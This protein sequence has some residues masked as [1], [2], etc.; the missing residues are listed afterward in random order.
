ELVER[1]FILEEDQQAVTLRAR[2][3]TEADLGHLGRAHLLALPE[4]A[5][6]AVS[7]AD[8]EPGLA[9]GREHGVAVAL[10]EEG[11]A[12]AG[13]LE[14]LDGLGTLGRVVIGLRQGAEHQT[15]CHAHYN[16]EKP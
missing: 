2:L 13:L 16:R 15:R 14:Q 9:D 6:R 1:P 10:L 7:A 3:P 11:G 12:F 4:D 5:A 8:A